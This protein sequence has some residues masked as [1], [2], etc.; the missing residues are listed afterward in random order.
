MNNYNPQIHHRRSIRLKGYDYSQAGL[1]FI[2]LCCQ[3]RACMFGS[4]TNGEMT[5]NDAGSMVEFQWLEL[6][7]RFPK[8]VLHEYAVMPNHFHAI[9]E[10]IA[11]PTVGATLVV[12]P[13]VEPIAPT[14]ETDKPVEPAPD[15]EADDIA[16]LSLP[17]QPQGIA[18]TTTTPNKTVGDIIGAFK[19]I[20]TVEYIRGVKTMD[21]PPFRV[22][23]WERNYYEH[24]IRNEGAY[25]RISD[26]I[27]DNPANWQE[28][29]FHGK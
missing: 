21:W 12:A 9:L 20:I 22:R 27:V 6:T 2:T 8:I 14:V 5:L 23:L 11:E 19:S 26:Y 25:K 29:K 1:Y 15:R 7:K 13:T 4:I 3:D 18:P 24:I 28:D 10:I 16:S 17:G